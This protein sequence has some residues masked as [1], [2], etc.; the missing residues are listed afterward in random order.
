MTVVLDM[1]TWWIEQLDFP[2]ATVAGGGVYNQTVAVRHG[3]YLAGGVT[4]NSTT[5][6]SIVTGPRLNT[7]GVR[8]VPGLQIVTLQ[9]IAIV[10][11]GQDVSFSGWA[12]MRANT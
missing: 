2:V 6:D 4:L 3:T 8:L 10:T 1:G 7:A 9:C 5:V 11:N 12:L